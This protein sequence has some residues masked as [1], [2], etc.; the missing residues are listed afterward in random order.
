MGRK[1]ML[2]VTKFSSVVNDSDAKKAARY[3]RVLVVTELVVSGT[4][5]SAVIVFSPERILLFIFFVDFTFVKFYYQNAFAF[6]REGIQHMFTVCDSL[7]LVNDADSY[8]IY[9]KLLLSLL[10]REITSYKS[11][12]IISLGSHLIFSIFSLIM[13]VEEKFTYDTL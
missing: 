13:A 11:R 3:S 1:R 5:C 6:L 4:Q 10:Q 7:Y 2:I 9:L 8:L 12:F